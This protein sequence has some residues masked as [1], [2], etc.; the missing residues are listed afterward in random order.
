M[1]ILSGKKC[2]DRFGKLVREHRVTRMDKEVQNGTEDENFN[3]EIHILDDMCDFIDDARDDHESAAEKKTQTEDGIVTAGKNMCTLAMER[4]IKK[5]R[6]GSG[7]VVY[8]STS[9]PPPAVRSGSAIVTDDSDES[10]K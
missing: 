7:P 4:G 1:H 10:E 5:A 2:S 9:A 8:G 3:E 6:R